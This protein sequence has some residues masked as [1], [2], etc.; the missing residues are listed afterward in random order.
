MANKYKQETDQMKHKLKEAED[1][2]E[3]FK[4]QH[5]LINQQ[6]EQFQQHRLKLEMQM[7]QMEERERSWALMEQQYK[8][9]VQQV[10]N[11]SNQ[12]GAMWNQ[13]QEQMKQTIE[14]LQKELGMYQSRQ[15]QFAT[16]EKQYVQ[17][18]QH[19]QLLQKRTQDLEQENDDMHKRINELEEQKHC[20]LENEYPNTQKIAL[21]QKQNSQL[22][23]QVQVLRAQLNAS[24]VQ[25]QVPEVEQKLRRQ[26]FGSPLSKNFAQ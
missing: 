25:K 15:Q 18:T 1:E 16:L 20:F 9:Q 10:V 23:L 6:L 3:A 19:T 13:C 21:L 12:D 22:V 11:K 2:V 24:N 17:Q 14:N 5:S 4:T 26:A 7:K 8:Q